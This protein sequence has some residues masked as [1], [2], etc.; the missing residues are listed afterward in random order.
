MYSACHKMVMNMCIEGL[1]CV[2]E[3][4]LTCVVCG[5]VSADFIADLL[6]ANILSML[7]NAPRDEITR[8]LE[9]VE[10]GGHILALLKFLAAHKLKEL[11]RILF[12]GATDIYMPR[13]LSDL[14]ADYERALPLSDDK[15]WG[16]YWVIWRRANRDDMT[17]GEK[18][19]LGLSVETQQL[20]TESIRI[21]GYACFHAQCYNIN[22]A[23]FIAATTPIHNLP[24]A[25]NVLK[26]LH[27]ANF[28]G[29]QYMERLYL[30]H[31]SELLTASQLFKHQ[32]DNEELR[33]HWLRLRMIERGFK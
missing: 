4:L 6:S 20:I 28:G 8:F 15:L 2:L 29:W 13:E 10:A 25:I 32:V 17:N 1:M 24:F 5:E 21:V 19:T 26:A 22:T 16:V 27:V 11:A 7:R 18:M 9:K 31:Y 3:T 23:Y 30:D 33:Y 14:A 12:G